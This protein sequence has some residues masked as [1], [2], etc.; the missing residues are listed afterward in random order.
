MVYYYCC[1]TGMK[2]SGFL[3]RFVAGL[4]QSIRRAPGIIDDF[5]GTYSIFNT[6]FK[7]LLP[8]ARPSK[9]TQFFTIFFPDPVL[10]FARRKNSIQI[11][12]IYIQKSYRCNKMIQFTLRGVVKRRLVPL[13]PRRIYRK[14][15]RAR[16]CPEDVHIYYLVLCALP[17]IL[18]GRARAAKPTILAS[19]AW[20]IVQSDKCFQTVTYSA[21][22]NFIAPYQMYVIFF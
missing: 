10:D 18:A 1:D 4:S 14:C 20:D 3:I 6:N 16:S 17:V 13:C 5:L 19:R 21:I 8:R 9:S 7:G 15:F 11:K 12:C 2:R 22:E